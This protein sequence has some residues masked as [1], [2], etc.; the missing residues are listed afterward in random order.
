MTDAATAATPSALPRLLRRIEPGSLVAI[1][2]LVVALLA[3]AWNIGAGT[4]SAA[5]VRRDAA[6]SERAE[7]VLS[8]MKDLE[9]GERGFLLTGVEKFLEPYQAAEARLDEY[10]PPDSTS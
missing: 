10:L 2:L 4:Q 9:T 3:M 8:A 6:L 1:L 7:A 5:R